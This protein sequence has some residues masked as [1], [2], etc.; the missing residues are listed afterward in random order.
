LI[1]P[2]RKRALPLPSIADLALLSAAGLL[3]LFC[4]SK[5]LAMNDL[6]VNLAM[7]RE[8]AAHGGFAD[9]DTF[10]HTVAG[11][12]FLNGTWGAQAL[13]FHL[14]EWTGYAGLQLV[15]A[16]AVCGTIV[17]TGVAS[18]RVSKNPRM[19][20]FG[21]LLA[22]WLT[23]QNLGLRP[24]LFSLPLFAGYA[25]LAMA[26]EGVI[27]IAACALITAVWANLHGSFIL[28]P[29]LSGLLAAGAAWEAV[30]SLRPSIASLRLALA[31]RDVRRHSI[32]AAVSLLAGLA[33]PYGWGIYFYVA[34]NSSSPA[35]RGLAEWDP[36]SIK[37]AAG[38][39]LA[40]AVLLCGV[41]LWR[42]RKLPAKR[43]L[44][45][46]AAFGF[47]SLTAIRHVVW[48]G[49]IVPIA[50]ARLFPEAPE[51]EKPKPAPVWLSVAFAIFWAFVLV[52]EAPMVRVHGLAGDADVKARFD[53]ETPVAL[54]AW[55]GDHGVQGR[56]FN[57][58]EWGSYLAWRLP[59][60]R[61]FVDV[62]IWIFPDDVWTEYLGISKGAFGWEDT[63]DAHRVEWA[64]LDKRFH[65]TLIPYMQHSAR[66]QQVYEDDLGLVFQRKPPAD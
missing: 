33:N 50:I 60:A 10:T 29:V 35:S 66:W 28:G 51:R 17:I 19:S 36:T 40:V 12:R 55:A 15:L 22:A 38:I 32:T 41:A 18:A 5:P 25:A 11:A 65:R 1:P 42:A 37:S 3:F 48:L 8:M 27:P 7:G 30:P 34:Q 47:L 59:E 53:K 46:L 20:G 4:E 58:M 2:A 61:L 57:S 13:F 39:R 6:G 31:D 9:V 14:F 43:D 44:P 62:R 64:I 63:L 23:V 52:K 54:A 26:A 21:A 49:M 24:Q 45:A 56:V 16:C